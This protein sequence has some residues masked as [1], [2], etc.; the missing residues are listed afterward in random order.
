MHPI[1]T[2]GKLM[3]LYLMGYLPIGVVLMI[4]FAQ[5]GAWGSAA[6][7]FVPLALLYAFLGMI[8]FY[9]CRAFPIGREYRMWSALPAQLT[10]AL[11]VGGL[12]VG[13]AFLW[14]AVLRSLNIGVDA[15]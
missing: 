3:G 11:I 5:Q 2:N 8:A 4:G 6:A 7:F 12:S 10:A 14:A 9:L 15:R 1:L 13:V